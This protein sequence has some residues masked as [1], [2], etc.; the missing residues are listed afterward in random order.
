M[1]ES[2]SNLLMIVLAV[3]CFGA[4]AAVVSLK[5]PEISNVF[6]SKLTSIMDSAWKVK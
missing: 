4:L 3:V 5:F 6:F 1:Q 2:S